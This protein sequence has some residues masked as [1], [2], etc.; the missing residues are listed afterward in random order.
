MSESHKTVVA[1]VD[2]DP[3][4]LQSLA[5]LLEAAGHSVLSF[6]TPQALLD[7][8][9]FSSIDCLITDIGMPVI[10]GFELQHLARG[11]L[12]NLPIILITGRHE[13]A[14]QRRS[15]TTRSY[16]FFHKPFDAQAL[17]AAVDGA[18]SRNR[19]G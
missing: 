17:L 8:D 6:S 14:D 12:P 11:R 16:G 18:V 1:I 9:G 2:D 10:D 19:G 15:L 5:D 4:I 7:D 3:R 13:I